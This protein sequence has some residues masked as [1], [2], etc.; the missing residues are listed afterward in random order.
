MFWIYI[1]AT[2]T[3]ASVFVY[4]IVSIGTKIENEVNDKY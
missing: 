3:I 4:G 2:L 1:L